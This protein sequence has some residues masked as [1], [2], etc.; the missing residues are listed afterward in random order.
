MF[1]EQYIGGLEG[2]RTRPAKP[3]IPVSRIDFWENNTAK[4]TLRAFGLAWV[5]GTEEGPFGTWN[6][7]TKRSFDIT[8]GERL[9]SLTLFASWEEGL[10]IFCGCKGTTSTGRSFDFGHTSGNAD[11]HPIDVHGG[12]C[13]GIGGN[14]DGAWL[15]SLAF[16]MIDDLDR[17]AIDMNYLALPEGDINVIS[18]DNTTDHN[19][20]ATPLS[21]YLSKDV[22]VTNETSTSKT[23]AEE[24]GISVSVSG[25]VFGIGASS[26]ASYTESEETSKSTSYS[27]TTSTT[28]SR[29]FDVPPGKTYYASAVYYRG[30]FEIEFRPKYVLYTKTGFVARFPEGPAQRI[31]GVAAGNFIMNVDDITDSPHG[32]PV[33]PP[34]PGEDIGVPPPDDKQGE[35]TIRDL[36]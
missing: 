27:E 22:S 10:R 14:R 3:H 16:C 26:D 2:Q 4:K 8:Y 34:P 35:F 13:V 24:L 18:I 25:K 30:T 17:A 11:A 32:V 9:T 15:N 7:L 23:W 19:R 5:D 31:S 29:T 6:Q 33:A 20:G 21:A 1:W 36:V 28:F 12:F